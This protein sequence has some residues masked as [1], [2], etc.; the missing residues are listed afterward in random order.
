MSC[1]LVLDTVFR[2]SFAPDEVVVVVDVVVDV[3]SVDFDGCCGCCK[4]GL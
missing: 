3:V 1:Y 4:V 2:S